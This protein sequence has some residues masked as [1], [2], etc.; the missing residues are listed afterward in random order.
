MNILAHIL[1][2]NVLNRMDNATFY[3]NEYTTGMMLKDLTDAVFLEDINSNVNIVRQNLQDLYITVLINVAGLSKSKA[4]DHA[5]EANALYQL[6]EISTKLTAAKNTG[7]IDSKA[8]KAAL[9][10]KI[11]TA[12]ESK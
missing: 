3:G 11:K 7:N 8:H 4:Y 10:F 12:M 6:N 5:S 1:N 9:I 2:P